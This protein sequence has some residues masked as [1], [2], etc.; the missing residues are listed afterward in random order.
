MSI[1]A[2]LS[3]QR[4][5]SRPAGRAVVAVAVGA[6]VGGLAVAPSPADAA[7]QKSGYAFKTFAYGSFATALDGTVVSGRTAFTQVSCTQSTG[8]NDHNF[9]AEVN[10]PGLAPAF[11]VDGVTSDSDTYR[12]SSG[13]VGTKSTNTIARAVLGE[14]LGPHITIQGLKTTAKAWADAQG[15]LHADSTV[16]SARIQS[17]TGNPVIDEEIGGGG[18]NNLLDLIRAS[19]GAYEVPGFGTLRLGA[20]TPLDSDVHASYARAKASVLRVDLTLSATRVVVGHAFARID[21]APKGGLL[22]GSAHGAEVPQVLG[23]I[24]KV[25][26]LGYKPMPCLGTDNKVQTNSTAGV[27]IDPLADLQFGAVEGSVRGYT[28]N[29]GTA[30]AQSTGRVARLDLAGIELRGVVGKAT[31]TKSKSGAL[32]K[33]TNGS[34][35]ASLSVD[36]QNR[37][38]PAPGQTINVAN[39][40]S[41]KFFVKSTTER[42]IAVTAVRVTLLDNNTVGPVGTV[43]NLGYGK[44]SI[45]R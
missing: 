9:V 20:S 21:R 3:K 33:S 24:A 38:I 41:L 32:S 14:E 27:S 31:V 23:D 37:P 13:V 18:I 26:R 10:G 39:V 8:H 42:S 35:V 30:L 22:G 43:I 7:L 45:Q 2:F 19:D 4:S 17:Q 34:T 16:T 29:D 6:L 25:G 28:R 5:R 11:Q 1:P 12:Y 40:A 15:R 44:A 36:G